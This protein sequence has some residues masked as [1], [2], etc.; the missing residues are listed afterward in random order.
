MKKQKYETQ[1]HN[2]F[3]EGRKAA[4]S[5]RRTEATEKSPCPYEDTLGN[6]TIRSVWENGYQAGMKQKSF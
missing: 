1:L 6:F 2:A 5:D 4:K 3:E